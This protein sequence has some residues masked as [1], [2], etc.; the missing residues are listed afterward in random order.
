MQFWP[1]AISAERIIPAEEW[2]TGHS[3]I[4]DAGRLWGE[5]TRPLCL[6]AVAAGTL[7]ANA[8][9][10]WLA[11]DYLFAKDLMAFQALLLTKTPR[12][13]HAP[14][15]GGLAALDKELGWFESHGAR[16]QVDLD[17]ASHP[18][19]RRYTDFLIRCAYTQPYQVLLAMLF[20]VEAAYLTAWSALPP[21]GPYAEFIERWSSSDFAAYVSALGGLAERH[22]HDA[23]RE[24]FNEVLAHEREFWRMSWEG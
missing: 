7:A 10:R 16:H 14:L 4:R 12:D 22:P 18:T 1:Q 17:V 11:Q 15:I 5:A 19:C 20:G 13:C 21:S 2:M 3:L 6:D 23:A 9:Q 24:H 8:F